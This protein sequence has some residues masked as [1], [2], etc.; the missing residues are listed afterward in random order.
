MAIAGR[1]LDDPRVVKGVGCWLWTGRLTRTGYG[2][3][4]VGDLR[5]ELVH[6]LAYKEQI[7]PIPVGLTVDHV[8][9]NRDLTC[10]GGPTCIH[11]RCMRGDHFEAVTSVE[12]VRRGRGNLDHLRRLALAKQARTT[13]RRGHPWSANTYTRPNGRRL[14]RVCV[15]IRE[16]RVAA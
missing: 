9:H 5:Y 14:C 3:L 15:A 13:C 10:A 7:G 4:Y 6:R 1:I 12:N 11:R 16:G 8:C 2:I